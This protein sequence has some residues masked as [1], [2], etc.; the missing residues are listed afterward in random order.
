L[1]NLAGFGSYVDIA[2]SPYPTATW[3]VSPPA[4]IRFIDDQAFS[5]H[6]AFRTKGA[7]ASAVDSE[8]MRII[9]T[10][11]VGI[12]SSAPTQKLDVAGT[13]KATGIQFET[14][15]VTLSDATSLAANGAGIVLMTNSGYSDISTITGCDSG[16][17]KQGQLVTF[18]IVGGDGSLYF[19]G[20]WNWSNLTADKIVGN[21]FFRFLD[22]EPSY[23]VQNPS[24]SS[25]VL[26]CTTIKGLKVWTLISQNQSAAW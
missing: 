13:I 10:G 4:S 2:G 11:N 9:S 23:G 15:S 18:V 21:I 14:Q 5:S 22:T 8:R 12:G 19:N 7:S 20:D 17:V 26:L 1:E 25:V 3:S 16:A 24:G 6:I